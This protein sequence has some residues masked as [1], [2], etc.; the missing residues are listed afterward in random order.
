MT[1]DELSDRQE[2]QELMVEYCYAID[3]RNWEALDD[4]FTPDAVI[5][6]TEMVGVGIGADQAGNDGSIGNAH[7]LH[8]AQAQLGVDH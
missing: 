1:L 6:Y 3:T 2:I 7:A 5:D 4:V 8:A